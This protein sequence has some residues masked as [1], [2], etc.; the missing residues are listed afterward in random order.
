[1]TTYP[2]G[3]GYPTR[4]SPPS[5][6][7]S[8]VTRVRPRATRSERLRRKRHG[9]RAEGHKVS[10]VEGRHEEDVRARRLWTRPAIGEERG[11][12]GREGRRQVDSRR[13]R[14]HRRGVR[15]APSPDVERGVLEEDDG[16]GPPRLPCGSRPA[17]RDRPTGLPAAGSSSSVACV[18][19][20]GAISGGPAGPPAS[21]PPRRLTAALRLAS[22]PL[23]RA[24]SLRSRAF[25]RAVPSAP[26][27]AAFESSRLGHIDGAE[28]ATKGGASASGC[29]PCCPSSRLFPLTPKLIYEKLLV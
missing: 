4:L 15:Q 6:R 27:R 18:A 26:G 9:R 29:R 5:D 19:P 10:S 7:G 11:Q 24:G 13:D 12:A 17:R 21:P 3:A 16:V 23:S 20:R 22:M 25:V 1:M 8:E 2:R 14:Q 28:G